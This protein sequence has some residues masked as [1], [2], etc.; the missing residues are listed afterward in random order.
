MAFPPKPNNNK[1]AQATNNKVVCKIKEKY[2]PRQAIVKQQDINNKHFLTPILSKTIPQSKREIP[3]DKDIIL[4]TIAAKP[5]LAAKPSTK[6][7]EQWLIITKP[8]P[9]NKAVIK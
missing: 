2:I 4:T 8:I 1:Q 7:G 5:A 3:L 9:P 6:I